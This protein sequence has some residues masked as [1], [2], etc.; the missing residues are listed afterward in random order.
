GEVGLYG[1]GYYTQATVDLCRGAGIRVAFV[2]DDQPE[3]RPGYN[4]GAVNLQT[5]RKGLKRQRVPVRTES[6]LFLQ[7]ENKV[8]LPP[9]IASRFENRSDRSVSADPYLRNARLVRE[10][11]AGACLLLHPVTLAS[12]LPLPPYRKRVALFGF[13]GSGNIL[14]QHLLA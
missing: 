11:S 8:G 5:L 7:L 13:P 4:A 12:V 3:T 14:A 10:I 9:L 6:E 2:V 1:L